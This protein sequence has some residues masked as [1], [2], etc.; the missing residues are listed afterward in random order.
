MNT[1]KLRSILL[2]LS[3]GILAFAGC[4]GTNNIA[5]SPQGAAVSFTVTDT[6]PANV[7]IISFEVTLT[8]AVL[9][10]GA[11]DL[12]GGKTQRLEVK[13]L[14]TEA[15]FLSTTTVKPGTYTSI[16]LT[17][18]NPEV[19]FKNGTAAT[20]AGCAAGA[21]CEIQPVA[22]TLKA[23]F[24]FPGSGITINGNSPTGI[25]VDI[26]PDAILSAAMG[27]DFSQSGSV[28][29]KQLTPQPEGELDDLD[30]IRGTVQNLDTTKKT[31]DV[32]TVN[33]TVSITTDANTKFEFESCTPKP[34]DFACL[35]NGKVVEVDAK[36]Q[37]GGAFLARKVEFEDDAEDDE[38]EGV[39]TKVVDATH[40]ELVVLEELRN[41]TNLNL[42]N[43]VKVTLDPSAQFIIQKEGLTIPSSLMFAGSGDL[44]E[45]QAV[46]LRLKGAVTAGPPV[47]FTADRVRL[48]MSRFTAAVSGAVA[49]PNF[50][51]GS[52][53]SVFTATTVHV[54]T[55][56]ATQFEGVAGV[57]GLAD[58]D[59]VSLKGLLFKNGANPPELI[60]KKVRKR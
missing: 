9:N 36:M 24:T 30:D 54:Q 43:P 50:T 46:Q 39:I 40:F 11:V 22:G 53:P 16:D 59:T 6:P 42:G 45:G 26:S 5:P 52:L 18:S 13:R 55:Q 31:F 23:T 57:T 51:V 14:E 34:N 58:K 10:P 25:R 41:I 48:R 32:K 8:G 35:A 1:N 21:V 47:S 2:V 19:T 49:P 7:S 4:S 60:A 20:L 15:A 29:A 38:A 3:L 28:S 33:G 44:I 37:P 12:L 56:S 17:F 27:V